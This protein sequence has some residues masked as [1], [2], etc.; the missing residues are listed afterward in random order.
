MIKLRRTEI[1]QMRNL[2]ATDAPPRRIS[3]GRRTRRSN[4][5]TKRLHFSELDS[6]GGNLE[7]EIT[8]G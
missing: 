5:L 6:I 8:D 7:L 2:R 4:D 3:D 1:D